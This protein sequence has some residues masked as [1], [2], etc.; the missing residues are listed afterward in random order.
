M[1]L[2]QLPVQVPP[3]FLEACGYRGHARYVGLQ[4]H[5]Q[6]AELWMSDD[7]HAIRGM[8]QPM[9]TLWRRH[10][11]EPALE[12]FRIERAE[13]GRTPWLLVDR[14]RRHLFLGDAAA[15]WR[16]VETQRLRHG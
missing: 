13:L 2:V 1:R 10:G 11:G 7:G 8:A 5:E 9:V 3:F 4:W 15:V 12:R 16:T 6:P 14:N